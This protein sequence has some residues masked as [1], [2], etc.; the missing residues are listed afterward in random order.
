MKKYLIL[1]LLPSLLFAQS[2]NSKSL[3][4]LKRQIDI[5]PIAENDIVVPDEALQKK[6]PGLAILYSML[7][8]GMGE[9]YAG[10]YETGKYFTIADAVF[11]GALV[12][13]NVYGNWQKDNY[14]A[15]AE[16]HAGIIS[17]GKD[18]NYYAHIGEYL[19]VEQYN[20]EQDLGHNFEDV[21]NTETHYWSWESNSTRVEYRD[22]WSSSE[23]A[24]NNIR[25]AAGALVLN[26]LISAINAVR[27]VTA[28]NRKVKEQI[29]WNVSFGV[30]QQV[31]LP[32]S[33][34]VNFT[35]VF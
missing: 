10:N 21:Y 27:L 18:E 4:E 23:E 12:G 35:K 30:Q 13:L 31:N 20:R 15:Y 26:R 33:L 34:I 5:Q 1:L 14:I 29:T 2:N 17:T 16:T 25:F 6:N 11:W 28:H 22:M 19:D 24:Y 7:L 32:S 3:Q 9:L 8:P